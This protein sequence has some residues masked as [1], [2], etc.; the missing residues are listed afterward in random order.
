MIHAKKA[1][2]ERLSPGV[3]LVAI[4][5]ENIGDEIAEFQE[6]VWPKSSKI[7]VDKDMHFY[8]ALHG[9]KLH[10]MSLLKTLAGLCMAMCG[11]AEKAWQR[12]GGNLKGEGLIQGGFL[13]VNKNGQIVKAWP[14]KEM[15]Q[16]PQASEIVAAAKQL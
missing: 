4:V 8:K 15:G 9:G 12:E 14:S 5:K 6:K 3:S 7:F 13:L 16:Y 1:D 2:L 11:C 10:K